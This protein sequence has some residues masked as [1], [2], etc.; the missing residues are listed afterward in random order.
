MPAKS[1]VFLP[2]CS[3]ASFICVR[4]G[5]LTSEKSQ[6]NWNSK[7]K[8][9]SSQ[10]CYG[11]GQ[12]NC[13][14]HQTRS[15]E[16]CIEVRQNWERILP[17]LP[18]PAPSKKVYHWVLWCSENQPHMLFGKKMATTFCCIMYYQNSFRNRL[19]N[20]WRNSSMEKGYQ[21]LW[22]VYNLQQRIHGKHSCL[23]DASD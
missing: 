9:E 3:S 15:W 21:L 10:R 12:E 8:S 2:E 13:I 16:L 17:F 7:G 20:F 19:K 1:F 18:P 4:A 14:S 11:S 22:H 5:E 6:E 23:L